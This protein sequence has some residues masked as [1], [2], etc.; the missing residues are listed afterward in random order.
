MRI[1]VSGNPVIRQQDIRGAGEQGAG[2]QESRRAGNR[3][4][5]SEYQNPKFDFRNEPRISRMNTN[6]FNHR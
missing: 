2:N 4:G 5:K 3:R 1:R 6:L